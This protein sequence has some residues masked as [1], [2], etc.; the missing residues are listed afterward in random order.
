MFRI[1]VRLHSVIPLHLVCP[2]VSGEEEVPVRLKVDVWHVYAVHVQRPLGLAQ[3]VGAKHGH[4]DVL[5][6]RKLLTYSADRQRR[7]ALAI[8]GVLFDDDNLETLG[9]E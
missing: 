1:C 9:S 5:L 3:K 8:G 2:L 4:L 6:H 7:R